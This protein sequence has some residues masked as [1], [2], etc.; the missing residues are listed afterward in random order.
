MSIKMKELPEMER[1]YEKL[2]MY[3]AKILSNAELLAII[4]KSGTKEHTSVQLAQQILNLNQTKQELNFL[5]DLE[6]EDFMK[7]KGIGKVKAIQLKAVCELTNRMAIPLNYRQTVIKTPKDLVN[8][9]MQELR[10]EKVER[11]KVVLLD[12]KNRILKIVDIGTGRTDGIDVK[13]REVLAEPIRHH[14]PKIIIV[15]NHPTGIAK[16]SVADIQFTAG[17]LEIC[18]VLGIEIMDHIIIGNMEYTS[19]FTKAVEFREQKKT[20]KLLNQKMNIFEDLSK[21]MDEET[22]FNT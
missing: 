7:I 20:E 17:L 6:I 15:H 1:P 5:K 22:D 16:P 18:E 3:G 13:M 19:I 2:E 4:I 14:A 21:N 11:L 12:N 9:L 10:F 8:I